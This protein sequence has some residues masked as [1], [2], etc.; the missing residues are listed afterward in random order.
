MRRGQSDRVGGRVLTD[1]R[2]RTRAGLRAGLVVAAVLCATGPCAWA[3]QPGATQ[4]GRGAG[5]AGAVGGAGGQ[6]PQLPEP[7][8]DLEEAAQR[9]RPGQWRTGA[10]GSNTSSSGAART[11]V[12]LVDAGAS[13]SSGATIGRT[14]A[15]AGPMNP[16]APGVGA[17]SATKVT[18]APGA[19]AATGAGSA[20][21]G[22]GAGA[23]ST[24]GTGAS[25]AARALGPLA[26]VGVGNGELRELVAQ[27][28]EAPAPWRVAGV[29]SSGGRV[30]W[31][32]ITLASLAGG[33]RAW[34][35]V[36]PGQVLRGSIE[37]RTGLGTSC[38]LELEG[39]ARVVVGRMSNVRI[40]ATPARDAGSGARGEGTP[41]GIAEIGVELSRGVVRVVALGG[42]SGAPAGAG[43]VPGGVSGV[44]GGA[45]LLVGTP[46][47]LV[48][49]ER[50]SV[51]SHD[52]VVGTRVGAE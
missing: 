16:T 2:A 45:R 21:I 32:A 22:G 11:P 26:S 6:T 46:L 34:S 15:P 24:A 17:Q 51:V 31:R 44:S 37:L 30:Q 36:T 38:V 13:A 50:A 12:D 1:A 49:V 27:R 25:S 52:A 35:D 20:D 40:F 9:E 7:V 10:R 18:P 42:G 28:G 39:R 5:G 47:E 19:I 29:T 43:E 14:P 3:Q 23:A 48:R 4:K 41:V 33:G 8:I